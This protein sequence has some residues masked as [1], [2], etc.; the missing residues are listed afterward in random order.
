[1]WGSTPRTSRPPTRT[2][3]EVGGSSPAIMERRVDLP[4]P[5]GPTMLMNSPFS[6][7]KLIWSR[8]AISPFS[9]W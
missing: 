6:M 4:Q 9:A 5:L 3:P 1:M 2:E 7:E 8:A